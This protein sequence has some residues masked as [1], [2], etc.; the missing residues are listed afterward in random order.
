MMMMRSSDGPL[1]VLANKLVVGPPSL[2]HVMALLDQGEYLQDFVAIIREF[3]PEHEQVILGLGS[4]ERVPRFCEL[5]GQR[6]FPLDDMPME[7]SEEVMEIVAHGI[8]I[9]RGGLS[10]DDYHDLDRFS[11]GQLLL[12]GLVKYPYW[13]PQEMQGARVALL[14]TCAKVLRDEELIKRIPEGGWSPEELHS[15][16]DG[17]RFAGAATFADWVW[18]QTGTDFLDCD[19]E[20]YVEIP[21]SREAVEELT[22]HH[23]RGRQVM[24]ETNSLVDWLDDALARNFREMMEFILQR[25]RVAKEQLPLQV[26][27][28]PLVEV[29]KDEEEELTTN[30]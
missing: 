30:L 9:A 19:Y 22:R 1:T 4:Y 25:P 14:E 8:P 12:L 27:G 6:Y 5:F 17:S 16:L 15:M 20:D 13:E 23:A 24:A 29:F 11:P 10:Y 7:D 18:H 2:S 3:L 26:E 28:K 21:W